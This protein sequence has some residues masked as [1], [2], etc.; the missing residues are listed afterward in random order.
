MAKFTPT[1]IATKKDKEYTTTTW[2]YRGYKYDVK[3]PNVWRAGE[4]PA[5][6][7]HREQQENIDNMIIENA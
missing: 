5:F 7:Q 3:Y 1:K 2:E 6:I 4:T